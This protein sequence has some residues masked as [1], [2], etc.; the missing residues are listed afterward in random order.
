[1]EKS[2]L[3][4]RARRSP[5]AIALTLLTVLIPAAHAVHPLLLISAGA[6]L[7][8]AGL[9]SSWRLSS[10]ASRVTCR[11]SVVKRREPLGNLA[12]TTSSRPYRHWPAIDR[13]LGHPVG[14]FDAK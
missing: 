7:G 10:L 3:S 14:Q 1:M 12:V 2:A 13:W 4:C 8:L 5:L 11:H 6:V 9:G